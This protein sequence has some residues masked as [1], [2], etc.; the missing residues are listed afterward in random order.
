MHRELYDL[1]AH[2]SVV[3][4]IQRALCSAN[5][6]TKGT[7]GVY[8]NNTAA[9]VSA[10][11]G[12]NKLPVTGIV[13]EDTWSELMHAPI[14]GPDVRSL[15][16]T[17]AFEGHGYSLVQGNWDGAWLTWGI[18]GFTL[19]HGEIQKIVLM[20]QRNEPASIRTA[21]GDN[22][23]GLLQ[24]MNSSPRQQEAWADSIS[25]GSRVAE[26]WQSAFNLLG[27]FPSVQK[28][29]RRMAYDDYFVPAINTAKTLNLHSELGLALSSISM[30]KTAVLARMRRLR[31]GRQS[32]IEARLLSETCGRSSQ[33][34]SLTIRAIVS[35]TTCGRE[36]WPLPKAKA[37]FMEHILYSS[38]GPSTKV[39][40]SNL[41][42]ADN[43]P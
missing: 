38:T 28:Q 14:P 19:K 9:A 7:D 17:A 31:Y 26:P 35:G 15:E 18:I 5:F 4:S 13:D 27:Q 22:A 16:L 10:F 41:L 3:T 40:P 20:I 11:Q 32:P 36:N 25:I 43:S 21:F 30:Y 39:T 8:G 23:E 2:G 24:I 42:S 1:G 34:L 6:D 37:M 29:Q 12:V 33:T